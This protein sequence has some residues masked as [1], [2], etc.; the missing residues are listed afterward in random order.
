MRF[1]AVIMTSIAFVLGLLPLVFA[2]GAASAEPA[3]R[4]N[5]DLRRHDRGLVV[6][7]F[8]IPMLYVT[9]QYVAEWLDRLRGIAPPKTQAERDAEAG[10]DKDAPAPA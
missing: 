8:L 3:R 5:A 4:R 6:G 1:R 9:F 7:L 10:R 2:H